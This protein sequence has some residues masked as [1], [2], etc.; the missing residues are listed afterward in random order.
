MFWTKDSVFRPDWRTIGSIALFVALV[1]I[2]F[3]IC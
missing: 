1:G 2:L 3:A